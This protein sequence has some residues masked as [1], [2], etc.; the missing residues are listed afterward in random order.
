MRATVGNPLVPCPVGKSI[1]LNFSTGWGMTPQIPNAP[2]SP[3]P[4]LSPHPWGRREEGARGLQ[5]D[6]HCASTRRSALPVAQ[7]VTSSYTSCS[8][9]QQES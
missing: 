1:Y 9:L 4:L 6:E 8:P 5:A 2:L 7:G 3:T